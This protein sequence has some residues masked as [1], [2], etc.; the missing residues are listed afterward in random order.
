MNK[1]YDII[2][3][4]MGPGAVFMAY[5]L[6]K[7]NSGKK[8]LLIEQGK[9]VEKR[10]CPIEKI[11]KC[12]KC[13]PFCNITSGFSGAGA[14]SDGK[15]SLYNEEDDDIYVGGELQKYIGV[16]KTKKLIAYTDKIYLEFGADKKLEGIEFK[17]EVSK[18]KKKAKKENLN[19]IDIPIRHLGT[20]KA[21][22]LYG[23]IEK[24]L[25]DNGIELMFE[26]IVDDLKIENGICTGVKVK[27]AKEVENEK[28]ELEIIEAEKV[29][30][31][32]GRKGANWLVD[33]CDKYNI[34][35][36]AGC[37]DIGIRYELPDSVMKDIN[38][39]MYEGKI[40]GRPWPFQD[41][42]R[43]F[44]QNPSGFVSSEVYD[45][46]LTL[47]NGHSY[48][49]KKS[50][51]TNLAIL[52]SHNFTYPFNKPIDYGRNVAKNLNELGNGN[53][54]VQRLG[55]ISRGKRTWQEELDRNSVEPTLKSA[56]P[57][58][59]TFAIGYRTMTDIL[60]F[61]K[62]VDKVVEG[63]ANPDNLLY[64]PEIK[65]Y[66]NKLSIDEKFE[67]SIKGLYS[68]GDGGGMTRGLMMASCSGIQMARNLLDIN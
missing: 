16:E 9:R 2:A 35:T 23:K 30:V 58:D 14:F 12:T 65:F 38:H 18:I 61:I 60:Q 8:I 52:V 54:V 21:H 31:A 48:K 5:E 64:G 42:V 25:E 3:V 1:K 53:V 55:D 51:N 4:G 17:E 7:K 20:E 41:K 56:V 66:S 45:H 43:T 49:D 36:K 29:V 6:V 24:Y 37:V 19:L 62:Q 46:N 68:I 47:V 50:T 33:M 34:E 27:K 59:I 63:F 57:G 26:T 39:Y 13:K 44:C 32:V 28:A 10:N 11:G 22:E 40:I 67:T 15:L